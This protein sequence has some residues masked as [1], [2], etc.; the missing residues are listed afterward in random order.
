MS[1]LVDNA[2]LWW[3]KTEFHFYS[4][5]LFSGIAQDVQL[6]ESRTQHQNSRSAPAVVSARLAFVYVKSPCSSYLTRKRL[7][8]ACFAVLGGNAWSKR[9]SAGWWWWKH[10]MA[11]VEFA[12][13]IGSQVDVISKREMRVDSIFSGLVK[14]LNFNRCL[15]LLMTWISKETSAK[16]LISSGS[17]Y[18]TSLNPLTRTHLYIFAPR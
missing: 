18:Q 12:K 17:E 11:L 9:L 1:K 8:R 14:L 3:E 7:L 10:M 2:S 6:F 16:S 13:R 15:Q 5:S 4:I